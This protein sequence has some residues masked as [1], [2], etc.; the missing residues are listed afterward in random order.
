MPL[1]EWKSLYLPLKGQTKSL[2]YTSSIKYY[3][4]AHYTFF[5]V[6]S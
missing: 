4:F 5:H 2:P 6:G 3:V 1:F